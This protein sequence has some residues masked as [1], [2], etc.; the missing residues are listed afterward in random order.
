[1]P[2]RPSW[3]RAAAQQ[4]TQVVQ[5]QTILT[6]TGHWTGPIDGVWTPELTQA[7]KDFQTALGVE[8]TGS[9]DAATIAAFQQALAALK[10]GTPPPTTTPPTETTPLAEATWSS[11]TRRSAGSSPPPTA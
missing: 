8:P 6:L 9:V 11:A 10:G 5:L 7:L 3:K 2:C 1:M 4:A